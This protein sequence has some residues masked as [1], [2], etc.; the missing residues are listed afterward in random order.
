[1]SEEFNSTHGKQPEND[2]FILL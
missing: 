2:I 1:M